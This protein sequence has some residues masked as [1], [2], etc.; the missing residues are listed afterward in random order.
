M[1]KVQR[2]DGGHELEL[3]RQPEHTLTAMEAYLVRYFRRLRESDQ[4]ALLRCL[5]VMEAA[6]A[7]G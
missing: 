7:R 3:A 6:P 4:Q 5:E 2:A 1:T